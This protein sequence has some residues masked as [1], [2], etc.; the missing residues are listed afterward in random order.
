MVRN[1]FAFFVAVFI[2][3]GTNAWA[4]SYWART[5]GGDNTDLALSSQTTPD[6]GFIVAGHTDSFGAG[7]WD[8]WILKLNSSGSIQWQKTYGGGGLDAGPS[9]QTTSDGGFIV[10]GTTDSF[11]AGGYDFLVLKLDSSGN[12]QWQ[13]TYGANG[14]DSATSIQATSDGGFIVTGAT[15]SFGAGLEDF[16]ILRL[17]SSGN[18]VWQKTYGGSL[19]DVATSIQATSD[20]GFIVAGATDSFGAGSSD[21]WILKLDSTGHPMA[22]IVWWQR[23][24]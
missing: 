10:A 17:D 11:G 14:D 19:E 7:D 13:K 4:Q 1:L 16:W 24:R 2:S 15:D 3:T 5:Y 6:G 12:I 21:F 9:I 8:F 22:E 20:G 18:I 23:R